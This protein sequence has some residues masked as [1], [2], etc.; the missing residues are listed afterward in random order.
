[1]LKIITDQGADLPL[2]TVNKYDIE[3]FPILVIDGEEE[4]YIGESIDRDTLFENMKKGK[5]YKTSQV[6][7]SY[8]VN[9]FKTLVEDGY[10]IIYLPLSSGISGTYNCAISAKIEVLEIYPHARIEIVDCKAATMGQGVITIKAAMMNKKGMSVDEIVEELED[11]VKNQIH[12]FT[13]GNL[14]YLYRGGRLSRTSKI[15]GGLL[16]MMPILHVDRE[17]GKLKSLDISRGGI[18]GLLK[19]ISEWVV[20]LSEDENFDPNQSIVICHGQWEEVAE[21]TKEMFVEKLDVTE[22]NIHIL[23]LGCAIGAHTGPEVLTIFFSAN[24]GVYRYIEL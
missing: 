7:R 3:V 23:D 21:K 13:V 9:R 6:P 5:V 19:K 8:M 1:M 24:P 14:E 17:D 10:D 15:I 11:I 18:N 4:L 22:C 2:E 20:K 16:N 12:L